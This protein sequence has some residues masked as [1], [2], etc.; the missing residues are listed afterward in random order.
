[1]HFQGRDANA[2]RHSELFDSIFKG[3]HLEVQE[4]KVSVLGNSTA[5]AEAPFST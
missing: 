1:M 4:V 2:H 3:S 5:I